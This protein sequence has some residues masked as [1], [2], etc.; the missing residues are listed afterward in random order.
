[1]PRKAARK[2]SVPLL[3][4]VPCETALATPAKPLALLA[5]AR[6]AENPLQHVPP[7]AT[8]SWAG[9]D[10]PCAQARHT[11][12]TDPFR[13][14]PNRTRVSTTGFIDFLE[15]D[16]NNSGMDKRGKQRRRVLKAGMIEFPGGA[17]SCMVRNLSETGAAL[18][19]PS[20]IG[21]PDHFTLVIQTESLRFFCSSVWR[22]E[23][24]I[25][26]EFSHI[27]QVPFGH[28]ECPPLRPDVSSGHDPLRRS[29]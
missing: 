13:P 19:V 28:A 1:M 17:F 29:P 2:V 25:G 5:I 16:F 15:F 11:W 21:I 8:R 22:R 3:R 10:R 26:V 12:Q 9:S 7:P 14:L 4:N 23:R 24:R 20:P 18:D 6:R 27:E